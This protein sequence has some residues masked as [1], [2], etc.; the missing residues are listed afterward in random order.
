MTQDSVQL[1]Q[2]VR[3]ITEEV[4]GYLG[5]PGSANLAGLE[6]DDVVCPGCDQQCV[7]KCARKTRKVIDA[8]ADIVIVEGEVNERVR[9]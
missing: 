2:L 4:L 9:I 6:L 3:T 5:A 8:G 7:E 1:E